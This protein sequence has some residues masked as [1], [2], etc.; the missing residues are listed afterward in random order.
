MRFFAQFY[1][2]DVAF[3]E[4]LFSDLKDSEFAKYKFRVNPG[5]I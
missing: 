5:I 1:V 2:W 4:S 3:S